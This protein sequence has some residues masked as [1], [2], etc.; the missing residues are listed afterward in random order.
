MNSDNIGYGVGGLGTF[1]KF[2][3]SNQVWDSLNIDYQYQNLVVNTFNDSLVVIAS[4][5][6][7]HTSHNKGQNWITKSIYD[8][9]SCIYFKS[10]DT[11]FLTSNL[12]NSEKTCRLFDKFES[13][14]FLAVK[15]GFRTNGL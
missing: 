2:N 9:P 8:I 14:I 4:I 10:K 15:K 6:F 13:G 1:Y 12:P 5:G 11:M 3:Q 7:V